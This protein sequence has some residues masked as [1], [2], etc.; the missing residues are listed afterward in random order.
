M[1]SDR[2][3]LLVRKVWQGIERETGRPP[4]PLAADR[5]GAFC[6]VGCGGTLAITFFD[7]DPPRATVESEVLG[8]W[9]ECSRGCSAD[10]ILG[11]LLR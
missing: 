5:V 1:P 3:S 11:A 4:C 6:P 8:R 7:G 9:G 2:Y 10:L